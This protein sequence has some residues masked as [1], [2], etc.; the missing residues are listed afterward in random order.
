M[1]DKTL[2]A[3]H[4]SLCSLG[5]QIATSHWQF[6]LFNGSSGDIPLPPPLKP[7]K[8][9]DNLQHAPSTC[10]DLQINYTIATLLHGS[11][12]QRTIFPSIVIQCLGLSALVSWGYHQCEC[13]SH[14]IVT[15]CRWSALEIF[16][17]VLGAAVIVHPHYFHWT[18]KTE[19]MRRLSGDP[20]N[21]QRMWRHLR[22]CLTKILWMIG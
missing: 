1:L 4:F 18:C 16:G 20:L 15:A 7:C 17:C 2:D 8:H 11:K 19:S 13:G 5:H 12:Y 21:T 22:S 6:C 9:P 14:H 3:F 10:C